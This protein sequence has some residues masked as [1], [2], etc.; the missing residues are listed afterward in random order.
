MTHKILTVDDHPDTLNAVV[1]ALQDFGYEVL[2]SLSPF[3]GLEIAQAEQPDLILLDVNMPGMDGNEFAR[4]LRRQEQLAHIPIIMF[5]AE[6]L[7]E[8]KMAG[9]EAG[10]DDYLLK[11]TDPHIMLE[12]IQAILGKPDQPRVVPTPKIPS[13]ARHQD[14]PGKVVV[15]VGAHGGAGTTTTAINLALGSAVAGTPTTLVD[16][17]VVQGHVALYLN[18]REYGRTLN[19]FIKQPANAES[20]RQNL[21]DSTCSDSL[22]LLLTE[23]DPLGSTPLPGTEH[24]TA[25]LQ[26]LVEAG[27]CVIIDLGRGLASAS[28]P[29]IERADDIIVCMQPTRVGLASVRYLL[30]K[31]EEE[32]FFDAQV[33]VV[34][35]HVGSSS[36]PAE[37]IEQYLKRPLAAMITV[38]P[39][40][41]AISVN[42]SKP[43]IQMDQSAAGE[44]LRRLA[45]KITSR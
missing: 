15:L 40:E 5:T 36:V 24:T 19:R 25:L 10:A 35:F 12:R 26:T 32:L 37:P 16:Y 31:M 13:S 18:H 33:A 38:H 45:H 11:P 20:V 3:T 21:T 29:I 17:D 43:L 28:H 34:G 27:S 9:F 2:S 8:Q 14:Q 7:P 39:K 4:Q 1:D 44:Q 41:M 23:P 30:Y 22:R 42:Q 6:S